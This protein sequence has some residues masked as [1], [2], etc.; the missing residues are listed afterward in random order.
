MFAKTKELEERIEELK[1][2]LELIEKEN[3]GFAVWREQNTR[4]IRRLTPSIQRTIICVFKIDPGIVLGHIKDHMGTT[5]GVFNEDTEFHINQLFDRSFRITLEWRFREDLSATLAQGQFPDLW[6]AA[7]GEKDIPDQILPRGRI[8]DEA[9]LFRLNDT[10]YSVRLLLTLDRSA[11]ENRVQ[12]SLWNGLSL[13]Y[14]NGLKLTDENYCVFQEF[15]EIPFDQEKLKVHILSDDC[16]PPKV[17]MYQSAD[18]GVSWQLEMR[19]H[20]VYEGKVSWI[21]NYKDY[22]SDRYFGLMSSD[23]TWLSNW[24]EDNRDPVPPNTA[25]DEWKG[26]A[27][28]ELKG[29][30]YF[31]SRRDQQL[32]IP[33]DKGNPLE[34]GQ[35]ILVRFNWRDPYRFTWEPLA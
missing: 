32:L 17:H 15:L 8:V 2:R 1:K 34:E 23:Y 4:A 5:E 6:D 29:E 21:P 9:G 11:L 31:E 14:D 28:V 35:Q 7:M 20:W 22:M 26:L 18:D 30:Y 3:I 19:E 13:V 16:D 27:S 25:Q 33:F 10:P 24:G 12:G